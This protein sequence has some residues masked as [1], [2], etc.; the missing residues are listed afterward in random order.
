[1]LVWLV[2]VA[3]LVARVRNGLPPGIFEYFPHEAIIRKKAKTRISATNVTCDGDDRKPCQHHLV[4]TTHSLSVLVHYATDYARTVDMWVEISNANLRNN[5]TKNVLRNATSAFRRRFC[6]GHKKRSKD[7]RMNRI[8][9]R[10]SRQRNISCALLLSGFIGVHFKPRSRSGPGGS[11]SH[12]R[13]RLLFNY[14]D[15]QHKPRT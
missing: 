10:R 3:T 11:V 12:E 5:G 7:D 6:L 15:R 13:N 1:M 8:V 9:H 2:A 14:S 4:D